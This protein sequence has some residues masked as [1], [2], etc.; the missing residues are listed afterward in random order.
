MKLSSSFIYA[1]PEY[2][3]FEKFV[4]S[5]YFRKNIVLDSVPEKCDI[6]ISALGFYRLW[7]N[8]TEITKGLLAP[9]ISNTDQIV[10]FDNY[11]IEQYLKTGN[12]CIGVQLGN[13]MQNCPGG[14]VWNFEL[15]AFRSAP[16]LSFCIEYDDVSIEAD[17]TVKTAA[18]PIYFD[19]L[20][21]GVRYDA[22]NEIPDWNS[23][24]FDDSSWA[25]AMICEK[26]AGEFRLCEADPILP[27][28][29]EHTAVEIVK[30]EAVEF[31]PTH[32]KVLKIT[33][34]EKNDAKEYWVYDFGINKTGHCRLKINGR[35]GQRIELQYAECLSKDG[36]FDYTN[37]HFY[38][39][40][41]SQRDVFICKGG[42]EIFEPV[43]TYHG[44]QYCGVT[45]IDDEQ[46]TP[47]LLTYV[48]T[49]SDLKRT[50]GFE[51]SDK[52]ANRLC[53]ITTVSDLSNFFYFPTDCPHREKN[54]W[55]GDAA[56]SAEHM[57]MTLDP[58][59]SFTEW[60]RNIRKAM[61]E[62]GMIP[63]IIPTGD[64]GYGWGNGPAWDRVLTYLPYYTYVYTGDKNILEENATAIFRYLNYISLHR[65]ERGT[66][67]FGLGDWCPVGG[68]VKPTVEFTSTV[69]SMS[70]A[71][72]ASF[73]FGELGLGLQKVFA[74]SL[75]DELRT[76]VRDNLINFETMTA[77]TRCQTAQA[78]AIFH[79]VFKESEK[80]KAFKVLMDIIRESDEHI[81]FGLLGSRVLFHVL[82]EFGEAD[83][84]YKMIC[85][86][87][88]PSYGFFLELGM[89]SLPEDF[90]DAE[91][92][93][94]DSLNHHFMG[95][96]LNWFISSVAGLRYNPYKNDHKQVLIR[97]AF[98]ESL[99]FAKAYYDSPFGRI[100]TEWKRDRAD[101]IVNVTLPENVFNCIVE[102]PDGWCF[103]DS[104]TSKALSRSRCVKL[105]K[106]E[107][108]CPNP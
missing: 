18:S 61:T 5:P 86:R 93:R 44:F 65:T 52:T 3:T 38:P 7:I 84:A 108:E 42:E 4:P 89:N 72:K 22:R 27:T 2:T 57:L 81:D 12:N 19:D 54:G 34:L 74:D 37:I 67:N 102:A 45:G 68:K 69:C 13:G 53:E 59:R 83:L 10:Y 47:E 99:S 90:L 32:R 36:K 94:K 31:H 14:F 35:P 76:A 16:K 95:D 92:S 9:Y 63:G 91:Y 41:Y 11:S 23:P 100:E 51:C 88:W 64:W 21:C 55:T 33:P 82:S 98:V 25:N 46:A 43:F 6:T 49:N 26:P 107:M 60:L 97:P 20:R 71:E 48:V 87:D 39:D 24:D 80:P 40:G 17:E 62:D 50:G 106:N 58:A 70:I 1:S 101:V 77:D 78:M 73:I 96:I 103:E 75:Y 29:E 85:R 105:I 28:G 8:G 104:A 79:N 15:A 66:V 30:R 56:V